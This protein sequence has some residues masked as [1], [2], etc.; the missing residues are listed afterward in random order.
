MKHHKR[1][2]NEFGMTLSKFGMTL[3]VLAAFIFG[4]GSCSHD[5]D[6]SSGKSDPVTPT[7]KTYTE[8]SDEEKALFTVTYDAEKLAALSHTEQTLTDA[9]TITASVPWTIEEYSDGCYDTWAILSTEKSDATAQTTTNITLAIEDNLAEF[10]AGVTYDDNGNLDFSAAET[11][12]DRSTILHL[13]NSAGKQIAAITLKQTG[14]ASSLVENDDIVSSNDQFVGRGYDIFSGAWADPRDVKNSVIISRKKMK[15]NDYYV[16]FQTDTRGI[17]TTQ[18]GTTLK[19]LS[20][21]FNINAS[22]STSIFA[23]SGEIKAAYGSNYK[24]TGS[25]EYGIYSYNARLGKYWIDSSEM[26]DCAVDEN[27]DGSY[28]NKY[29]TDG[30]YKAIY[31]LTSTYKG[32]AGIK[33]LIDTYGTHVIVSGM[34]GARRDYCFRI[35]KSEVEKGFSVDGCMKAGYKSLWGGVNVEVEAKYEQ[36]MKNSSTFS[37]TTTKS[38]GGSPDL[39]LSQENWQ[40]TVTKETAALME[41]EPNSLV[42]IWYLCLDKKRAEAIKRVAYSYGGTFG[43]DPLIGSIVLKDGS[44][45]SS[46]TYTADS[47]NPA[48]GV[49][50]YIGTGGELGR[51]D[52]AYMVG[53][54]EYVGCPAVTNPSTGVPISLDSSF[55]K[56]ESDGTQ[57]FRRIFDEYEDIDIDFY[58]YNDSLTVW[59]PIQYRFKATSKQGTGVYYTYCYGKLNCVGTSYE[60]GWFLPSINELTAILKK[61]ESINK[62]LKLISNADSITTKDD[63][64]SSSYLT[65]GSYC[66]YVYYSNIGLLGAQK[67]YSDSERRNNFRFR[68]VFPIP[69]DDVYAKIKN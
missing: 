17:Y 21:S 9:I 44:V 58:P 66:V 29:L 36:K 59:Q 6:S 63:Y 67:E 20:E 35:N 15:D 50:A 26:V 51:K 37:T 64:C 65:S 19:E 25:E 7:V 12:A 61:Y 18:T 30:A 48:V 22:V 27:A 8:A 62:G 32:D 56:S 55:V 3:A 2:R 14:D 42:P 4:F 28:T 45:V 31:G 57:N 38:I 10:W 33:K 46:S 5:S 49:I 16:E 23:F 60:D 13:L 39:M 43:S 40:K 47:A 41:F 1:C 54:K 68:L 24:E 11:P 34:M 52:T 53:V 69:L